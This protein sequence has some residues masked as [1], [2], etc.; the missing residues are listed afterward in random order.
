NPVPMPGRGGAMV[1]GV[2]RP[3]LASERVLHVG[4]PV[5]LVV[6][7]TRVAAQDA[8][9]AVT[10]DYAPLPAVVDAAAA[11]APGAPLLWPAAG[12][13]VAFDWSAPADPDGSKQAQIDHIFAHAK[14]VARVKLVNQ[15]LVAASLEPRVATAS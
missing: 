4:E 14:H 13:N 6:A 11:I 7:E 5:V 1:V 9:E 8:A 12:G 2:H 10:I 15:R 3:A